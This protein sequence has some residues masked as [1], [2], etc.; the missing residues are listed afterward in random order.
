MTVDPM[1]AWKPVRKDPSSV[2]MTAALTATKKAD[3]LDAETESGLAAQ[4]DL[5]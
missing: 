5:C 2:E 4:K 1:V 3:R